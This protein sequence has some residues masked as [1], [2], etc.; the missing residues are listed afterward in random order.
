MTHYFAPPIVYDNPTSYR[1]GTE[2]VQPHP[3]D[4][5]TNRM[6]S[7]FN[8]TVA[9]ARGRS[10][11]K[12]AGVYST[13]DTPDT[14]RIAAAE[15]VYLGGHVYAVTDAEAA[16]LVAAGY[17]VYTEAPGAFVHGEPLVPA[18]IRAA[19]EREA[20]GLRLETTYWLLTELG[21]VL[22]QDA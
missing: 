4:A 16:D 1:Q 21:D 14:N 12:E 10:V 2:R 11:L 9:R 19:T 20:N 3:V 18:G 22:L 17:T 6:F 5:T 7:H 13:V 15:E 8:R